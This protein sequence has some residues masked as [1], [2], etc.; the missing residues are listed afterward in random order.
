M[1]RRRAATAVI[2]RTTAATAGANVAVP[3]T[4]P[5]DDAPT[6]A[7]DATAAVR[8][9]G[10]ALANHDP[11]PAGG[12]ARTTAPPEVL[13]PAVTGVPGIG[14]RTDRS[15]RA[16]P[17]V[18]STADHGRTE[19]NARAAAPGT[20]PQAGTVMLG[21]TI[22]V[23]GRTA[24]RPR[25]GHGTARRIGEDRPTIGAARTTGRAVT[26]EVIPVRVTAFRSAIATTEVHVTTADRRRTTDHGTMTSGMTAAHAMTAVPPG[27]IDRTSRPGTPRAAAATVTRTRPVAGRSPF[28]R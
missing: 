24:A 3:V 16:A 25:V 12:A 21:V 17:S 15:G 28:V 5:G 22:G 4:G 14:I 6:R 18:A 10:R 19:G 7:P 27:R 11:L 23:A 26:P 8:P 20:R 2:G 13:A 9:G 1:A